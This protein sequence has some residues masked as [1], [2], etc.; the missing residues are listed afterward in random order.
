MKSKALQFSIF[1]IAVIVLV[2]ALGVFSN[3]KG[4]GKLD[5]FAQALTNQGAEF[6]GAFW[7]PHCQSEKALFGSSAKYLPYKECSNPDKTPTQICIDKKIEGYPTWFF[8]DGITITSQN[9]PTVCKIL[10]GDK[11]EPEIC[12]QGGVASANG[13]TWI[14]PGYS[15]S[16][17]SPKDPV[18]KDNVYTFGPE[19]WTTGEIPLQF[20]AAQ[21]HYNLPL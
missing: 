8:K 19:A 16:I 21:I 20:L 14:F 3:N 11:G 1:I 15:F 4:S 2:V 10:P 17:H 12:Q 5:A 6:Y 7:C 9:D 13:K 18:K